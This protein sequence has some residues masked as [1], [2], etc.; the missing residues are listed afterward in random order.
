MLK[1]LHGL[2]SL[3]G[4][5]KSLIG[6]TASW[7]QAYPRCLYSL[8][9]SASFLVRRKIGADSLQAGLLPWARRNVDRA[10]LDKLD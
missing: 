7:G 3:G 6:P 1:R 10:D 4:N 8:F 9:L 5:D 2:P